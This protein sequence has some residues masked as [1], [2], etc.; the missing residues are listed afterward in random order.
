MKTQNMIL[1]N[2]VII[3][4][5]LFVNLLIQFVKRNIQKLR[6]NEENTEDYNVE[7]YIRS[8]S[9]NEEIILKNEYIEEFE[10]PLIEETC[11]YIKNWKFKF[12]IDIEPISLKYDN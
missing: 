5:H 6:N 3:N 7:S 2:M 4:Y 9:L 12:E 1:K 11:Y 8:S 10:D